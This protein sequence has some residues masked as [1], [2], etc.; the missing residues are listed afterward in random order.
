MVLVRLIPSRIL[1]NVHRNTFHHFFLAGIALSFL[2]VPF[3]VCAQA[4]PGITLHYTHHIFHV[5]YAT[6]TRWRRDREQWE[7][8]GVPVMVP[9]S[10]RVDGDIIPLLPEGFARSTIVEWDLPLLEQYLRTTIAP[11]IDRAAGKVTIT[12]EGG[13]LTFDGVGFPGRELQLRRSAVL[14]AEALHAGVQTVYLVVEETPPLVQVQS[15]ELQSRGVR[16]L[17]A[18][19]ESDYRGSPPNRAHNILTGLRRFNGSRIARGAIF[20]FNRILGRVGPETGYRKELTILGERT[21]PDYGG[22][23]CQVSTTAY[24]GAWEAGFPILQRRNHSYTVRYYAPQGTDATIYPPTVDFQFQNNS[25]G[26]L[27]VQTHA[28]D[29]RAYFLYYGTRETRQ[30][31]L[32]GPY[33]WD[34]KEPPSPR[35]ETTTEIPEG[36]TRKVGEATPGMH[37]AWFRLVTESGTGALLEPVYSIYEARP[38]FTQIGVASGTTLPAPDWLEIDPSS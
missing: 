32:M 19:G 31:R 23:L 4:D 33:T 36:T 27:I 37:A 17:V 29:G 22:G 14:I 13:V 18:F 1:R 12:D 2:V 11:S 28:Q 24:R 30:V 25:P 16:E 9:A 34:R 21:I 7:F 38:L 3:T 5:P 35:S 8:R 20:S 26:D 15:Q 6:M 10:F